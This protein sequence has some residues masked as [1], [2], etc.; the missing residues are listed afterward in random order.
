V[1]EEIWNYKIQIIPIIL[2]ILIVEFPNWIRKLKKLYYVPIYFSI[3]PLRELNQEL[4]YYVVPAR[5][6]TTL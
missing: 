5:K 2:G 6:P 1:I 4:S 3:F